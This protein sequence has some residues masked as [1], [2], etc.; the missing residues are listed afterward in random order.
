MARKARKPLTSDEYESY[1]KGSDKPKPKG[2]RGAT[3]K[4]RK[5]VEAAKKRSGGTMTAGEKAEAKTQKADRKTMR[6]RASAK[7]SPKAAS[8]SRAE[9]AGRAA[10]KAYSKAGRAVKGVGRAL[11]GAAKR[12]PVGA[13]LTLGALAAPTL[14]SAGRGK[15]GSTGRSRTKR[16]ENVATGR[17]AEKPA[18][19]PSSKTKSSNSSSPKTGTGYSGKSVKTKGGDYPVYKK[20]SEE[21]K[22]FREAF[23]TARKAGKG[24]FTWQGRK[25]NTKTK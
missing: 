7:A 1:T 25:Y 15:E 23:A 9:K 4:E 11:L 20:K 16:N 21:G 6:G 5:A 8:P 19:T 13:A 2:M 22:S 17:V 12:H 10:G 3:A 18:S 24:E 14:M